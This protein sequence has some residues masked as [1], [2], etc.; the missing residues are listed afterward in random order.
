M[1]QEQK[2]SL[3]IGIIWS[4]CFVVLF[5]LFYLVDV[6]LVH[7]YWVNTALFVLGLIPMYLVGSLRR[8]ELGGFITWKQAL[9]SIWSCS[10][11]YSFVSVVHSYIFYNFIDPSMKDEQKKMAVKA[12]EKWRS[13]MGDQEADKQIDQI[14]NT[15]SMSLQNMIFSFCILLLFYFIISAIMAYFIRKND[16]QII[17]RKFTDQL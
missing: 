17:E 9:S 2:I 12:I 10:V 16:P 1:F 6:N 5:I 4:A 7:N 14:M 11:V 3:R 15:N 8:R 13:T